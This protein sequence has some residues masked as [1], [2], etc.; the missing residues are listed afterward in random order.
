MKL[1]DRDQITVPVNGVSLVYPG[2]TMHGTS[3]VRW[4]TAHR[5][6]TVYE[7]AREVLAIHGHAGKTLMVYDGWPV[8][9]GGPPGAPMPVGDHSA[10]LSCAHALGDHVADNASICIAGGCSC[11]LAE[12]PEFVPK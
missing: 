2:P 1:E 5:S 4:K 9:V 12:H 11:C 7:S 8:T 10:C 6:T 3:V